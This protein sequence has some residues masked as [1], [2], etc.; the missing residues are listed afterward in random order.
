MWLTLFGHNGQVFTDLTSLGAHMAK[1]NSF[2][3]TRPARNNWPHFENW[4]VE[5]LEPQAPGIMGPQ[6]ECTEVI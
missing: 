6:L 2:Y 5:R 3:P 4:P 1:K